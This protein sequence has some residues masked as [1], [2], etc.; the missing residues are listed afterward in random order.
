LPLSRKASTTFSRFASFLRLASLVCQAVDVDLLEHLE[1]RLA[2]HPGAEL[3]VTV[4]VEEL[5][6]TL[7]AQ[8]IA[9]HEA[10][11]LG[12]DD[13][14]GLA[15]EDLL[16][17]LERDVEHVAD[18]RRQALQE[19]DVGDR[20]GQRDVPE[21]LAPDLRL[22]DLDAALLAHDATVLHAL[23][24]AAV[25]LVVLHRPEDLRAEQTIALRLERPVVDGLRLLHLAVRPLADLLRA[26]ERDADGAERQ[27]VLGLLEEAEDVTHGDLRRRKRNRRTCPR[28]LLEP[29][30]GRRPR[31]APPLP[32]PNRRTALVT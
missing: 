4:L 16:Q 27:R 17:V 28:P 7:L 23:V 10:S 5:Q 31:G 22:D 6:I 20:R 9:P 21:P 25:A 12:I 13:D 32:S 29:S 8:E 19:P 30:R 18:A 26:R 2:A 24:L 15:I 3:V 1:D 14:V 11:L